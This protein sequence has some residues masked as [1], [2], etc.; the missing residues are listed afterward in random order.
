ME[1]RKTAHPNISVLRPRQDGVAKANRTQSDYVAKVH[2]RRLILIGALFAIVI[3]IFGSQILLSQ[4]T[5]SQTNNQIEIGQQ[6]LQKQKATEKDLNIQIGQLQNTNYLEKYVRD[7]YMYS[8][9]GEQVYNL[10]IN[11]TSVQK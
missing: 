2:Q 4:R 8:K 1:I 6:K 3:L 7:K 5:Y 10:P 9:P 11:D